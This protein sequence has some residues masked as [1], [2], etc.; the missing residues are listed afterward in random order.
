MV[1][2]LV[3]P[4]NS[5]FVLKLTDCPHRISDDHGK[6][7]EEEQNSLQVSKDS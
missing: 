6:H 5:S 4:T 7:H 1:V 2:I 3:I